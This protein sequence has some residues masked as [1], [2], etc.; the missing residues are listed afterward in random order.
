MKRPFEEPASAEITPEDSYFRRR[1]LLKRAGL[2]TVTA[3]AWGGGLIALS[4]PIESEAPVALVTHA[5]GDLVPTV[6]GRYSIDP[7]KESTSAYPDIV[8]YNNYYELG[9]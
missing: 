3:A 7:R 6:R 1:E 9:L 5:D 8:G 2:V 4:C